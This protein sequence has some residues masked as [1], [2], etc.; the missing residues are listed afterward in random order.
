M[1]TKQAFTT[2]TEENLTCDGQLLKK[3]A[4]AALVWLEQ[5]H[6]HVNRLNVFPVPDG[7]TGTNMLLT[8]REAYQQIVDSDETNVSKVAKAIAYG[9]LNGARGNS[10]TIMSQLWQGF[11]Q[12]IDG[13]TEFDAAGF[14]DACDEAVR[15]AYKAVM[16]PT[17]G[18]ILT[19]AREAAEAV[20]Q[21]VES[22]DER[23]LVAALKTM[24]FAARASL[25]RTPTL[26]PVLKQAGVVDS[27]GQGLV[28]ILE[29]MLQYL[30]GKTFLA[31]VAVAATPDNWEQALVPDDE[32]GYGYDV[33]FRMHGSN[34][35][36]ETVRKAIDDLGWSTVVV[37]TPSLI[38]VHV[39]VH[40]PGVPISYAIS[41]GAEIDDVVVENMQMQ[42]KVFVQER[43]ERQSTSDEPVNRTAVIAVAPGAGLRRLFLEELQA[44]SVI[45]GGQTM[46]PST[47]DFLAIIREL[48][49]ENIILLP[50]NKNIYLAAKQAAEMTEG[51]HVR[52][53]ATRSIP[54]GISAMLL[55]YNDSEN[56][57]L[58]E[59]AESMAEAAKSVLSGEITTAT[60]DV[61]LDGVTV[62][63]GDLIG[64]LDDKL[65]VAGTDMLLVTR[66]LLDKADVT[67][68]ELVTLYHGIDVSPPKAAALI[69]ALQAAYPRQ[70]FQLVYG[71]QP[72]YPYILSIE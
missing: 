28:Y 54:Q 2:E 1:V 18:T 7:D 43:L 62:H 35:D 23:D 65:V 37:G 60:R 8:M 11:A 69:E 61:E 70:E 53:V 10:G 17:E 59:I 41:L 32:E 20:R 25:R 9:A 38:K 33:Q 5:N 46:N 31:P 16:T 40:D 72:L 30:S 44:A 42:Y 21:R 55:A 68:H 71:G 22:D 67:G 4:G 29:G 66:A 49:N 56:Q 51:K 13:T 50:N 57:P 6:E 47:G 63:A 15:M 64:L 12:G 27:G 36:V 26:L 24:V 48:P 34:L 58:D 39:H 14:A 45:G 19:V 3:L 52:V